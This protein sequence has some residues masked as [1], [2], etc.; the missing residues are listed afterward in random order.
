MAVFF[1][2]G[3]VGVNII[4]DR[5]WPD[6]RD[7]M[8]GPWI[9]SKMEHLR[10]CLGQHPE[11]PLVMMLGSSMTSNAFKADQ[12][13]EMTVG[14]STPV[15][16]FNFGVPGAGTIKQA[17]VWRFLC[18]KKVRPDF[19]LLEI[20]PRHLFDQGPIDDSVFPS[21]YERLL[22]LSA[23][24]RYS[25][26]PL[27]RLCLTWLKGRWIPVYGLRASLLGHFKN[28]E[29]PARGKDPTI[30][31]IDDFGWLPLPGHHTPQSREGHIALFHER[32][33]KSCPAFS[34]D[35]H[36]S[37]GAQQAL[38]ELLRSFD[39]KGIPVILVRM[40]EESTLRG[41]YAPNMEPTFQSLLADLRRSWGAKYIDASDWIADDLFADHCHLLPAGAVLFTRRLADRILPLSLVSDSKKL[42]KR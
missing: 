32:L 38:S 37:K 33:N 17:L 31:L 22:D 1:F 20:S 18:E 42:A 5:R 30:S 2:G 29:P 25:Q 35:Y 14:S 11:R 16:A 36:V 15:T 3:Q 8:Q 41:W 12:L 34:R 39:Q 4:I 6:V 9:S 26:I 19:L 10:T 27:Y 24:R 28:G 13:G 23:L 40:P 21:A 7:P